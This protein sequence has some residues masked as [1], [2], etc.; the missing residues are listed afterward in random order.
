MENGHYTL[1]VLLHRNRDASFRDRLEAFS[2]DG[3]YLEGLIEK[4]SL[5][6]T[7]LNNPCQSAPNILRKPGKP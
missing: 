2:K 5:P 3:E 7:Q 1:P 6:Q 4:R